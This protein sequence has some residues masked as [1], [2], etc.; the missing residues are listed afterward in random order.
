MKLILD[1]DQRLDGRLAGDAA[2]PGD[3][4]L[5]SFSGVMVLVA[6]VEELR[7]TATGANNRRGTMAQLFFD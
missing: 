7:E 2:L 3:P 1:L 6:R 4:A 5:R